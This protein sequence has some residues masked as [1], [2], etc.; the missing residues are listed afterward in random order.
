LIP[1]NLLVSESVYSGTAATVTV[2]QPLP[3]GGTAVANG[4]YPFVWQNEGPDPSFGVT[5]PIYL[6]QITTSGTPVGSPINVT[7]LLNNNVTTSF[8]S[9]SEL[10]L[11][12]SQDGSAV[13]FIAYLSPANALDVSNANTPGHIDPTNPVGASPVN[14]GTSQ[15]VVVQINADGTVEMTPV[16][17]YS[18]NNGRAAILGDTGDYYLVGNAGNGGNFKIKGVNTTADSTTLTITGSGNSTAGLEAGQPIS[19]GNIPAG[20]TVVSILDATDFVISAAPATSQSN[21]TASITQDGN[22]LSMLSD[23][24]GVQM[25]V[26]GDPTANTTVV[27]QVQGT[28]GSTTGYQRGF[29]LAD[30]NPATGQPYGAADKTG[31]DDNFR[32]ETIFNNTLYVTKGSGSNGLDTVYQ[33]GNAGSLPTFDDAG[34]LP[35]T[36]LPGFP[37]TPARDIVT[38]DPA[39]DFHPFGIWFA[40]ATTLYVA[41]EGDGTG[42]ANPNTGLE[43]WSLVNGVWQLDYTLQAGLNLGVPYS[44][45]NGP[46]GEVYPT[47]LDPATDGLRNLTGQVNGDGT[48]TLYAVTSTTSANT[49]PGADPNKL[50][51]ITD[52]LSATTLPTNEQ[53]TTL[54]TAGYGEVLR[55]VSFTPT[56]PTS[57]LLLDPSGKGALSATGNGSVS[58]TGGSIVVNSRSSQAAIVSGNGAVSAAQIDARSTATSGHGAFVGPVSNNAPLLADPLAYLS[59]PPVPTTV[60]STSTLHITSDMVLQPGLYIGG[61]TI[62]GQ[63]HV[64]LEPGVYYLQ[65]GGFTVSGQATVTDNG[66]GVLLYNAPANSSD[67]ITIS[68]QATVSLTG[69]SAAQLTDL[70]LPQGYQGLAIFQAA[71]ATAAISLSGQ[72]S[73]NITGTVYAAGAKVSVTGGSHLSLVGDAA[74]RLRAQLIVSDLTVSGVGSVSVDAGTNP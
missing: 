69:L 68:G 12:L 58:A 43:K 73:V 3:G 35:I 42:A 40:N 10:A 37:T 26:P 34:T 33:V 14:Q 31:K 25:I 62:S 18:G 49:D 8:S 71:N 16:N 64:V 52:N 4:S 47:A 53:F 72:S 63:A 28:F 11:N 50:V 57:I 13:T 70:S 61:I 51:A 19:G 54:E 66:Q 30:I 29:S 24:T 9:K 32:G 22:T 15:R 6:Q 45:A 20:A 1:G 23:N 38:D 56:P 36:P 60:Q 7:A 48:V 17:A 74:K 2:G 65:G 5:S 67:G 46:N 59:A 41:D 39:T 27:G 21:F 44:V 55:G